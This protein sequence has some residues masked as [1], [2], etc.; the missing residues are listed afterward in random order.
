MIGESLLLH[1]ALF[2]LDGL[3]PDIMS[4]LACQMLQV[5]RIPK[6]LDEVLR[7]KSNGVPSWCEQL[8]KELLTTNVLQVRFYNVNRF[9]IRLRVS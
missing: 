1:F 9:G 4:D 5:N 8:L 2:I 3:S 6:K 7:S